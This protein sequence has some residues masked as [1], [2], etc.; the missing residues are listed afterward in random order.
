MK[1]AQGGPRAERVLLQVTPLM[2]IEM[3][4][5]VVAPEGICVR[6]RL[7]ILVDLVA[8]CVAGAA[9]WG[10]DAGPASG[11]AENAP[12]NGAARAA[13]SSGAAGDQVMTSFYPTEYFAARIAG[14][15]VSVTC[16][17]P[18]DA[19]PIFWRPDDAAIR[20]YQGARLIVLNGAEYEKWAATVALPLTRVVDTA[21]GLEGGLLRLEGVTH[22]HGA[23]GSHTHAGV[24]G[25]T[26][27]DPVQA[28]A[29][30]RAI[31]AAMA[32]AW[33]E[34]EKAFAANFR[35]LEGELEGLDARFRAMAP[36][37]KG[38]RL[39]A[40]HPAY[41]YIARR[42]GLVIVNVTLP[43][44]EEATEAAWA[45]VAAAVAKESGGGDG[46]RVMLFE[47]EPRG[48]TARGLMEKYGMAS[49]VFSPCETLG[50]EARAKGADYL[51]VMN[52][53]LDRLGA[54]VGVGVGGPG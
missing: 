20:R 47:S 14:G 15:L 22:S 28:G 1:I 26:W 30:A 49:V 41:G 31:L 21:Q 24:D 46:R 52:E 8:V 43:P 13:A 44:E 23:G 3:G 35:G 45:E 37:L 19:D 17:V 54:A 6:S 16:P 9:L 53:N 2:V 10:C 5:V 27:M 29:Q 18:A 48:E 42:Y 34:H 36:A 7:R 51:K 25:H 4:V 11:A 12:A 32:R 33:P 50:A 38:A 40:G 39:Y